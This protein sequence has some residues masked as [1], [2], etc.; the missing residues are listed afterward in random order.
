[1]GLDPQHWKTAVVVEFRPVLIVLI[2]NTGKA[3]EWDLSL[4][5]VSRIFFAWQVREED[6]ADR[7]RHL[8]VSVTGRHGHLLPAR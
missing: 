3:F 1:M 5:L 8:H 6:F 4:R 7:L 2:R